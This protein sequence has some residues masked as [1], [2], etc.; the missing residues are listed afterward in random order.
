MKYLQKAA[1][2]AIDPAKWGSAASEPDLYAMLAD[3]AA[4]QR[5]AT[6]L[7]EYAPMAE[8]LATRFDHKLYQGIA[9][10]AW[11]VAYMMSGDYAQ[12][13]KRLNRALRLF[14]RLKTRWQEGRTLHE[15]GE[16]DLA[17]G[18]TAAARDH[19]GR[20]LAAFEEMGAAPDAAQTRARLDYI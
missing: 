18:N 2:R 11:G 4:R 20:A 9:H 3:V 10:R 15:L 14:R 19:F 16:L 13:E 12:A 6:A 8:E 1:V 5:D 7:R 17:R